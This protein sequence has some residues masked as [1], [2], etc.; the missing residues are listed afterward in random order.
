MDL[1]GRPDAAGAAGMR[2]N[3]NDRD[4]RRP[5]DVFGNRPVQPFVDSAIR[6]GSHDDKIG[7]DLTGGFEDADGGVAVDGDDFAMHLGG[8][9]MTA[10]CLELLHGRCD[11]FRPGDSRDCPK[12]RRRNR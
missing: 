2:A 12:G 10:G 4:G 1:M 9:E 7:V 11:G 3:G 5:E 8:A 6:A